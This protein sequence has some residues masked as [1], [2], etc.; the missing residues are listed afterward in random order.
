ML[1]SIVALMATPVVR[2]ATR[3]LTLD[4]CI[5]LGLANAPL[6]KSSQAVVQ[7]AEAR[8]NE[9]I[10]TRLP[11]VRLSGGYTRESSVPPFVFEL[12]TRP[13]T[14]VP[15]IDNNYSARLSVQEPLFT[16]FKL[17][18]ATRIADKN[19]Q[20]AR[21]D[22]A[23]D[24][25]ELIYQI[26]SSYWG[27]YEALQA[28]SVVDRNVERMQAH[29][30]EVQQMQTEGLATRNDV[31]RVQAQLANARLARVDAANAAQVATTAL[32][33]LAG[34]TLDTEDEPTT[35]PTDSTAVIT[36]SLPALIQQAMAKRPEV[37]AMELRVRAGADN[38]SLARSNWY[39]QIQATGD[40]YY[41]RPNSRVF[42][43]TDKFEPSWDVGVGASLNVWDWGVIAQQTAEAEAQLKQL[44]ASLEQVKDGIELEVTQD[45]L[46]LREASARI[47]AA[48]TALAQ[49]Q[50]NQRVSSDGFKAGT[51]L[52]SDLL[53]AETNLLQA[54]INQTQSLVGLQLAAEK[55]E[56]TLGQ[57]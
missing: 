53:D 15:S 38:V 45:Y 2:G 48:D 12:P 32:N 34:L 3:Q 7:T 30:A 56:E 40:F 6:L 14:L 36:E 57:E 54:Q 18:S 41:S 31:L 39:P 11:S 33:N 50:E 21:N 42:P 37:K 16:G 52:S 13:E 49:A 51:V 47:A 1:A 29:L 5:R 55:L 17:Q 46:N 9:A 27:L 8:R 20:A 35:T 4:E 10:A 24:R 23:R 22:F 43:P 44:R 26:E 28:R 25:A 19:L